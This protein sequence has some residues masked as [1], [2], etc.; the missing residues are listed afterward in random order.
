ML[1]GST[2][3]L[4][5]NKAAAF[6]SL[7]VQVQGKGVILDILLEAKNHVYKHRLM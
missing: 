6:W 2:H 7:N 5:F 3:H 4:F 1:R